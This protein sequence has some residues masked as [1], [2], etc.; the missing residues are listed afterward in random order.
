MPTL[1]IL[2]TPDSA[3]ADSWERQLPAGRIALRLAAQGFPSGT[4]PG[5]A[6]VVVLDAVAEADLP[7]SLARCPTI[8]VGEPR[9]LPYE[10]AKMSGRAKVYL[11]YDESASRLR[12]FL[13][14]IEEVAEKQSLVD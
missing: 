5:F 11:S 14:L 9:S 12:E 13:P 2:A 3:L 10:Q 8:F 7:S 1:V 6:A 4:A